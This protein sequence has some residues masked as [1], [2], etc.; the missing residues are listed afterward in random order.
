MMLLVHHSLLGAALHITLSQ[1]CG[2]M[3]FFMLCWLL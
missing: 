3:D 1:K 2:M